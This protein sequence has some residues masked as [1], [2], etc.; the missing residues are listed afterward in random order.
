MAEAGRRHSTQTR[1]SKDAIL[2]TSV[3]SVNVD[4]YYNI[5]SSCITCQRQ[6]DFVLSFVKPV[7]SGYWKEETIALSSKE[8]KCSVRS[9][10]HL[11]KFGVD[12]STKA[13]V[14]DSVDTC[15]YSASARTILDVIEMH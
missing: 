10:V 13:L 5:A 9:H 12:M 8:S 14:D 2:H 4:V 3:S 1:T 11:P 15:L 6:T 7:Q